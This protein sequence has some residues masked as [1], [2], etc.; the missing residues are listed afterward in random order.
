MKPVLALSTLLLWFALQ[1]FGTSQTFDFVLPW[2]DAG[3]A[4]IDLSG[5]HPRPAGARGFI[6]ATADGH[7]A[8]G[9]GR[10]RFWGVNVTFGANFPEK[11]QAASVAQRLSKYGVNLVRFHHMDNQSA[12]GQA[13]GIWKTISPDREIDPGQLD[14]LDYFVAQLARHGIYVDLNLLVS[15]PFNRGNDLP[16]DIDLVT[17]WKVRGALGFFDP[18]T[19]EL[20]KRFAADLLTHVNPYT[21]LAYVEDPAVAFVEINNEN[22]LVQ[23][24]LGESLDTLPPHYARMLKDQWNAWLR[25]RYDGHDALVGAW[26]VRQVA[27]G[28]ELLRNGTFAGSL[29]G[30][31][32]ER[33]DTA[34]ATFATTG[35]GPDGGPAARI[36]VTAPGTAGWHVQFNQGGIGLDRDTPYTLSFWARASSARTI[37]VD[38]GMAQAPWS[39]LGF[40]APLA[41]TTAWQAFT[42][43]FTVNQPFPNA[44]INFSSMGLATGTVWIAGVSLRPGGL[45]GLGAGE[46]LDGDGIRPFR[47]QGEAVAR[48]DEARRDWFRFL[49]ET[50]ERAWITLRDHV[51]ALGTRA[52]IVGTVVGCSTPNLMARFDAVDTHAYWAHPQFPGTPWDASDWFV[53]NTAMVNAPGRAT[54]TGLALRRVL[55][56]PHLVTEYNHAAPNTF[57]AEAFPF[58]ATYGALQDFDVLVPFDYSSDR[59]WDA[60]RAKGFFA[61]DQ[62]PLKMASFIPAALA[63]LRADISPARELVTVPIGPQDEVEQLLRSSAWRLVDASTAGVNPLVALRHRVAIAIPGVPVPDGARRP[64][65]TDVGGAVAVSD[66]GEIRWDASVAGRGVVSVDGRGSRFVFGYGGGRRFDLRGVVVEPGASLQNGFGVFAVS[67]LDGSAVESAGRLLVTAIGA[68]GNTGA[69]WYAY[70]QTLL[71][72]P[73]AEGQRITHRRDWGSAPF[74]AEGLAAT[75]TLSRPAAGVSVWALDP[76]GARRLAVPVRP[77]ADGAQFEIGAAYRTL[78]YEIEVVGVAGHGW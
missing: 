55:G 48:T 11:S 47:R 44:R 20:Q 58:L 52:L 65:E 30:W 71:P 59:T 66:T 37:S 12:A 67:A 57:Q 13:A 2:D 75:I 78:W 33:H 36:A 54:A 70:P 49:L 63:F 7:L 64:A 77:T 72:F 61:V 9:D 62:N 40:S 50:E 22:G 23:A 45:L 76:T 26:G 74:L 3:P 42:F 60:G 53:E 27:A 28:D 17:D 38:A 68:G 43:T 25:Q 15:R 73:P 6:R 24:F 10:V 8:D 4:A 21:G 41:L 14:R 18:Q 51:R 1:A 56:K 46:R 34:A 29:A 31:N 35:D 32:G 19:R 5:L 39:G 69:V 16:A